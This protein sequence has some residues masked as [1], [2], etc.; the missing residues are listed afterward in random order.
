MRL[1]HIFH[2]EPRQA[3]GRRRGFPYKEAG[4]GLGGSRR[5]KEYYDAIAKSLLLLRIAPKEGLR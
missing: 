2:W 3:D 1:G 5:G 4:G